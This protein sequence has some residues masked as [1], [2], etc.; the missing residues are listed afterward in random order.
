MLFPFH[1]QRLFTGN[2]MLPSEVCFFDELVVHGSNANASDQSRVAFSLRYIVPSAE[3]LADSWEKGVFRIRPL[4][5]Q[6][7]DRYR[8]NTEI[9]FTGIGDGIPFT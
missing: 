7:P 6:R 9:E 3:S 8:L 1:C 5:V 2:M 4:L